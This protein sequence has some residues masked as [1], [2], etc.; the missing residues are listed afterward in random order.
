MQPPKVARDYARRLERER[1]DALG[2]VATSWSRMTP[3]FDASW[4]QVQ[5]TVVATVGAAQLEVARMAD[6][7]VPDVVAV[8]APRS[9]NP[10]YEASLT[11]WQGVTGDGRPVESLA[12]GAVIQAKLGVQRGL[13]VPQALSTAGQWLDQAMGTV[14]SDTHRGVEQMAAHSRRVGR[15]VRMISGNN[16]CGRCIILAGKVY[17]TANAFERHPRCK[18]THVPVAENVAGDLRT[19]P[20]D[21]LDSLDDDELA[22]VLGSKANAQAYQDGA[23]ANQLINAYRKKGAV[24]KAQLYSRRELS[25]TTEGM[26]RRGRAYK[27]MA[28]R[29]SAFRADLDAR[30]AGERYR[31]TQV[32]RLMPSSIYELAKDR[33][34]A[35]RL[36]RTYGWIL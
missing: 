8:T 3:N 27:A 25:F 35:V 36:L 4:R 33:E 19:N 23:D 32:Q 29:H 34:D 31:R 24:Q 13:T 1:L 15:Y 6:E 14:L 16:T 10:E 2:S 17:R 21:Y 28:E 18:C 5:S 20:G 9:R 7:Y 22:R 12:A 30:T 11:A 26:T